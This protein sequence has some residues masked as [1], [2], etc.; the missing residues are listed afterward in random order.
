M[1]T[2]AGLLERVEDGTALW[3]YV[4]S[5]SGGHLLV[6]L[7]SDELAPSHR[8]NAWIISSTGNDLTKNVIESSILGDIVEGRMKDEDIWLDGRNE[9]IQDIRTRLIKYFEERPVPK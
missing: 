1:N 2:I 9:V 8:F 5:L 6:V 7:T 4:F 3:R